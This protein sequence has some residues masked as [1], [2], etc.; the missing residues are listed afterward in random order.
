MRNK[1]NRNNRRAGAVVE[2]ALCFPLVAMFVIATI[3]SCNAIYLRQSLTIAAHES[4]RT[5]ILPSMTAVKA[6]YAAQ[7]VLDSRGI[8]GGAIS[9]TPDP[10][11]AAAGDWIEVEVSAPG[12]ANSVLPVPMFFSQGTSAR[13]FMMKEY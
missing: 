11:T 10:L 9:I 4:A 2:F 12:N 5:A 1:H 7:R 13:V 3:E 6:E 8:T